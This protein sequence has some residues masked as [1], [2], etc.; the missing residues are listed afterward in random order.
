MRRRISRALFATAAAGATVTTLGF[1]AAG[2]AGAATVAHRAP[3]RHK[4]GDPPS[5]PV[6]YTDANCA[7]TTGGTP[8]PADNCGRAGY[9]AGGRTFRYAQ[10]LI[11]VPNHVG[12]V[13][14]DPQIYV[15]LDN[16]DG[17]TTYTYVRAGVTPCTTGTANTLT[18]TC[19]LGNTS[20]W[21]AYV[22][23][24]RNGTTVINETVNLTPS[25][26]GDRVFAS[27]YRDP[28]GNVVD[29]SIR[30][31]NGTWYNYAVDFPGGTFR[32]AQAQA[33][34]TAAHLAGAATAPVPSTLV[35]VRDTQF[36]QGAFTTQ[37]GQRGTFS[38]PWNLSAPEATSNGTA[39]GT[40]IAE[41][42]YLW[43]DGMGGGWGDAF[44][45]WRFPF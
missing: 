42:S 10:A 33:D 11:A 37:S 36:F 4:A 3:V 32:W 12:V 17:A 41:P 20:H 26:E 35:K 43:N 31:P 14:T 24:M 22:Q 23:A 44:G 30:L 39:A 7:L 19:P 28:S 15:G 16:S 38:G 1:A 13:T 2:S 34:W 18:P 8:V 5:A 9:Q 25:M 29:A 45:V 6:M 21:V 40:L 27:L